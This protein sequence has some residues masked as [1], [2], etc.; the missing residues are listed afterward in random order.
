[1]FFV[2]R[3]LKRDLLQ[4]LPEARL[5]IPCF[6]K[7]R[8]LQQGDGAQGDLFPNEL[9]NPLYTTSRTWYPAGRNVEC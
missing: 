9:G 8:K 4:W 3:N 2:A 5:T 6:Q 1:M 7:V